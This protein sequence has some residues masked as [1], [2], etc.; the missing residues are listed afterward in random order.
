MSDQLWWRGEVHRAGAMPIRGRG[1]YIGTAIKGND[2]GRGWSRSRPVCD[3]ARKRQGSSLR[4]DEVHPGHDPRRR[5][6]LQSPHAARCD[7]LALT[8]RVRSSLIRCA[9]LV[10]DSA[11]YLPIVPRRMRRRI[12]RVL[13]FRK[14][15]S[16]LHSPLSTVLPVSCHDAL[17]SVGSL[18]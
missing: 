4:H 2:R 16:D 12:N 1:S 5:V 10:S 6:G 3:V 15:C 7:A 18:S 14:D 17:Y 8:V 9:P 13:S 11:C